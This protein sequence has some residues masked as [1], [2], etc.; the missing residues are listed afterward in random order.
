MSPQGPVELPRVVAEFAAG[1]PTRAVWK[2]ELGGLTFEIEAGD[3]RQFMKW[4]PTDS[5][6]DLSAEVTRLRWAARFVAVPQIVDAGADESGNWM[7]TTGL[8]GRMAVDEHWKREP[9]TAVRALGRGLRALHEAMPV[10]DCPFDWSAQT[11]LDA[12]RSRA[13]AGRLN[14]ASWPVDLQHYGTV[15]RALEVL[16]DIPT[17]DQLVVCHGDACAPNTLIGDDGGYTGHV[18]FGALGVADRWADLAVATWSTQ[19][20]YG[21][22]WEQ[23][24]LQAYGIEADPERTQYY[25]LLWELSD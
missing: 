16:A 6:I 18:D 10:A 1:R 22:G 4:T 13:A 5:G 11:R 9:A 24:L 8:P 23:P 12:V 25:R 21:L 2:N 19:W 15:E 3:V 7:V 17:V 14:P 20:N